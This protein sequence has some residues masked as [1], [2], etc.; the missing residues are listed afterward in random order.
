MKDFI[1][2]LYNANQQLAKALN[3]TIDNNKEELKNLHKTAVKT[4]K[5]GGI[6][7]WAG[8][9]GSA[10]DCQHL[11]T[12][13]TVRYKIDRPPLKSICL[14]SD[15][16]LITATSN[17]FS[18]EQIFSRQLDSLCSSKDALIALS[19]SGNSLNI[20]NAISTAQTKGVKSIAIF[21]R[22][23]KHLSLSDITISIQSDSTEIIQ[24]CQKLICHRLCDSI[25]SEIYGQ[26]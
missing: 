3:E 5:Q 15:P 11:S 8:N 13:L 23:S 19:T 18:F 24:E 9:G 26:K 20:I 17:D 14:T 2:S 16:T 25:E 10:A 4:L 6:I 21:G 12:E 7:F 22:S 1:L